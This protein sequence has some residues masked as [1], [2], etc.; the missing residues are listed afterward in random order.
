MVDL[1]PYWLN[2]LSV[3]R[4]I[5]PSRLVLDLLPHTAAGVLHQVQA[6][7]GIRGDGVHIHV[8]E[9]FSEPQPVPFPVK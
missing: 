8:H 4:I 7:D 6:S 2:N 9:H 1:I 5:N 3:F